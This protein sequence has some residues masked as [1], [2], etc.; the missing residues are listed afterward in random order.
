MDEVD[1]IA[2]LLSASA[3]AQVTRSNVRLASAISTVEVRFVR[4]AQVREGRCRAFSR[5]ASC[6]DERRR[7]PLHHGTTPNPRR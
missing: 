1:A 7:S 5:P 6:A 2:G 3:T 4:A